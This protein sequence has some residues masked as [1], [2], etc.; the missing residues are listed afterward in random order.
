MVHNRSR[1]ASN[2]FNERRKREDEAPRLKDVVPNLVSLRL[3]VEEHRESAALSGTKHVRHIVVDRAPALFVLGCTDSGCRDG[4]HDVTGGMLHH[5][6]SGDIEFTL[7]DACHG[8]V[9]TAA[10]GR[11]VRLVATAAYSES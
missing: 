2:R 8:S 9:G 7:D 4:G 11:I 5:L 6:R 10:C 3:D 1:E